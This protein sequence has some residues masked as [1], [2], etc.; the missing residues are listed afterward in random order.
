MRNTAYHVS[1][2]AGGDVMDQIMIPH[3][4]PPGI[5]FFAALQPAIVDGKLDIIGL[6]LFETLLINVR[7]SR[8][9][10][11]CFFSFFILAE[12]ST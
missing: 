1:A 10:F 2:P 5:A 6:G 4:G 9:S 11:L 12:Q 8:H 7:Q 3:T